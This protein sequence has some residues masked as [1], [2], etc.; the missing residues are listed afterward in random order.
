MF[1][2]WPLLE[3]HRGRV[4]SGGREGENI[5]NAGP[6]RNHEG[7]EIDRSGRRGGGAGSGAPSNE[8]WIKLAERV[9][10]MPGP[11]IINRKY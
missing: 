3:Q 4:G 6:A 8:E 1:P 10:R 11:C 7:E 5:G 2:N 9:V